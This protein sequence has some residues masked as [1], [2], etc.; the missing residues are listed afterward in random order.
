MFTHYRVFMFTVYNNL[1]YIQVTAIKTILTVPDQKAV[2][3]EKETLRE[4]EILKETIREG[5][6]YK[7]RD[8]DRDRNRDRD[9][10]KDRERDHMLFFYISLLFCLLH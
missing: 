6:K 8:K 4:I 3:R 2:D 10:D 1:L 7:D 5:E 9:K